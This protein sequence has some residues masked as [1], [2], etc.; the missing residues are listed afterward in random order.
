MLVHNAE[1]AVLFD[2][3]RC[4]VMRWMLSLP[5]HEGSRPRMPDRHATCPVALS[6]LRSVLF[7]G[8]CHQGLRRIETGV[9][10]SDDLSALDQGTLAPSIHPGGTRRLMYRPSLNQTGMLNAASLRA[11]GFH[12]RPR[13]LPTLDP[14]ETPTHCRTN[15]P[16]RSRVPHGYRA[17]IAVRVPV[18]P[19][20]HTYGTTESG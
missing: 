1:A 18:T 3:V 6:R 11:L 10:A 14:S 17:R 8:P 19:I 4:N 13:A 2:P 15:C 7:E 12:R 16:T 9:P 5:P 20:P